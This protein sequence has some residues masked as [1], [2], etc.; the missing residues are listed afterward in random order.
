MK[1]IRHG[2]ASLVLFA[3][4]IGLSLNIYDSFITEYD[5]TEGDLKTVG[6]NTGNIMEQLR[7]IN[8]VS[9]IA[10]LQSAILKLNPP[11]GSQFDILGGLASVAIGS[12]K[13]I[14]GLVT[15]PFEVLAVII[16]YYTE[17]PTILIELC[18]WVIIYTGFI[19][20]SAYLRSDI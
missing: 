13:S 20:L 7:D 11:T 4:L 17:L 9:G 1:L 18:M 6:S 5:F 2:V 8:I 10:E 19:L 14:A 16:I 12:L 3:V 15:T